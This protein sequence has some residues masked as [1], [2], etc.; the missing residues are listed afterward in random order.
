MFKQVLYSAVFLTICGSPIQ[1]FAIYPDHS[2]QTPTYGFFDFFSSKPTTSDLQKEVIS[3]RD[4]ITELKEQLGKLSAT[5]NSA[6]ADFSLNHDEQNR[7][8]AD[9]DEFQHIFTQYANNADGLSPAFI[10]AI[11]IG[12]VNAIQRFIDKGIDVT[13]QS[14]MSVAFS[15]A[16]KNNQLEAAQIFLNLGADPNFSIDKFGYLPIYYAA[17]SGSA[18]LVNFLLDVGAP[19]HS[20]SNKEKKTKYPITPLH[21][22]CG[23]GNFEVIK[24]LIDR[25]ARIDGLI[26]LKEEE[27][28]YLNWQQG[29]PLDWAICKLTVK[30]NSENLD[31]IKFL[32]EN[33]ASRRVFNLY[34]HGASDCVHCPVINEYLQNIGIRRY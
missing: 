3:L 19:L 27:P 34:A 11:K 13:S 23:S 22:A 1:T 28:Q 15:I 18:D 4:E 9:M 32:V 8:I 26:N 7:K 2:N 29:T 20:I 31:I 21:I 25:R 30:N 10:Y 14:A 16:V 6:K 33:G 12:D 24:A 5:I 17:E